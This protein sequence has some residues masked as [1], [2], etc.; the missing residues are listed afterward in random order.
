LVTRVKICGLTRLEDVVL[1]AN[2]GADAVGFVLEA[3]SPRCISVEE[4]ERLASY[5]GPYCTT[6]A[7]Y[8]RTSGR[9]PQLQAVQA[10]EFRSIPVAARIQ[11]VRLKQDTTL[12]QVKAAG[13]GADAVILDAFSSKG[14]GGT[15]E[16][17]DWSRAA[18]IVCELSMP[19]ILAGGLTPENVSEAIA[20][21]QPYAVDVSSGVES[22]P[23]VKDAEK[24]RAFFQA[25]RG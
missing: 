14:Y 11:A 5:A 9:F 12:E 24:L 10:V 21:V 1:A 17:V 3:T 20:V 4:A 16:R 13:E 22:A 6:V 8:G 7:V 18:E 25:V 2:L 19:V 23:G 15:G